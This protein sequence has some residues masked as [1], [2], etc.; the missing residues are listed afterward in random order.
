MF[1]DRQFAFL[2]GFALMWFLVQPIQAAEPPEKIDPAAGC[3]HRPVWCVGDRRG[4][5]VQSHCARLRCAHLQC[6]V[7]QCERGTG[8]LVRGRYY[9]QSWA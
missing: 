7:Q 9:D 1:V 8:S 3:E 4:R 6:W 5:C 2:I